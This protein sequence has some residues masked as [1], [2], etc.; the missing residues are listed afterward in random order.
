MTELKLSALGLG[1]LSQAATLFQLALLG[2]LLFWLIRLFR[3]RQYAGA[4]VTAAVLALVLYS[5]VKTYIAYREFMAR[6]EPAK[7]LFDEK[8]K[9]TAPRIKRRVE[10]EEGLLLLKIR[11][12]SGHYTSDL[13]NPM[14]PGAALASEHADDGYVLGFLFDR[15]WIEAG[16]G[17]DKKERR[18]VAEVGGAGERGFRYVEIFD[19]I[20][21]QRFR[22][23]ARLRNFGESTNGQG[24]NFVV[25]RQVAVGS[26]PRYAVTFEDNI[27]PDLRKH[28]VAG[29]TIKVIDQLNSEVIAEQEIWTLDRSQGGTKQSSPWAT[30][31]SHCP[32]FGSYGNWTQ[33][34]VDTVI[35][36]RQGN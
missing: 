32:N 10:D 36:A 29:T 16:T 19:G 31:V 30:S 21:N 22:L 3:R 26:A 33:T 18:I 35:K 12:S 20:G 17:G 8:C 24:G 2:L 27:S 14:W 28:W 5:P 15:R 9:N 7:A 1:G 11:K 13:A 6:Y 4:A 23:T 25:D 34:F